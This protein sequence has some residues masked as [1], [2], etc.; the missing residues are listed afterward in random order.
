MEIDPN[1]ANFDPCN[2]DPNGSIIDRTYV[3]VHAQPIAVFDGDMESGT[4]YFYLHDRLGSVRALVDS[5]G[6]VVNR[7]T[8]EP[9]GFDFT[10]ETEETVDNFFKFTGQYHD[11]E[12]E[13][14]YLRAR[15]YDLYL[16]RFVGRDPLRGVFEE[17]LTLHRYLYCLNDPVNH[18][19]LTGEKTMKE[20]MAATTSTASMMATAVYNF[21]QRI[22]GFVQSVI[23]NINI[24]TTMR[25]V[26]IRGGEGVRS[27]IERLNSSTGMTSNV[28]NN[29]RNAS[30][31]GSKMFNANQRALV[32]L[33]KQAKHTGV[34]REEARILLEW[35]DE[36]GIAARNDMGTTH[37]IGGEHI[38]I[39]G[40]H[41]NCTFQENEDWLKPP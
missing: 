9:Y 20:L 4:K 13:Q 26:W 29:A 14:Y 23:R 17:P 22:L 11:E 8:Y 16:S 12:I 2:F 40:Y 35:A 7:Y 24:T 39:L 6:D 27:A 3:Y 21:G 5:S 36:F 32:E 38:N 25:N 1:T 15:Q 19:D 31:L 10:S 18:V 33:A 37:W 34:T 41:I 28:A 30:E